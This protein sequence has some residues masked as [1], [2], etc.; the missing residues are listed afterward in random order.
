MKKTSKP[1]KRYSAAE[2]RSYWIGYGVALSGSGPVLGHG[3][4]SFTG[5]LNES[6]AESYSNG[7]SKGISD[8][9]STLAVG[10]Y[11]FD[12]SKYCKKK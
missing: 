8:K 9:E 2:K 6:E 10:S 1:R 3:K 12:E 4:S 7:Y 11:P 5:F